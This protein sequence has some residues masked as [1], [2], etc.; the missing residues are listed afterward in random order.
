MVDPP[1]YR[2]QFENFRATLVFTRLRDTELEI[3]LMTNTE[4]LTRREAILAAGVTAG[5]MIAP[6]RSSASLASDPG[7]DAEPEE[8]FK[9]RGYYTIMT[10]YPT[11][12]LDVWKHIVDCMH[13]DGCNLLVY[14]LTGG[15][16]SKKYPETWQHN[17]DHVNIREDFTKELIDYAHAKQIRV[18]L[19]FTPFGYDGVNLHTKLHPELIAVGKDGKSTPEFGIFCWGHSLCPAQPKSQEFMLEYI[20]EMYFDFYPNADGLFI[21]SS[22]YSTCHCSEC[23]KNQGSGHFDNEFKFVK[24]IS[25]DVW[26]FKSDATIIVYPHYFSGDSVPVDGDKAVATKQSFDDRWTLFF[27]PHSTKINQTLIDRVPNS[28]YW[29]ESLIF[30]TPEK[31]KNSAQT[32]K[33]RRFNGYV[34]S[35][36]AYSYVPLRTEHDGEG[37]LVN[38][39]QIPF[40][41]GWIP[42]DQSP[43]GTLPI[44]VSRIAFREFSKDP[45]L[46][47]DAFRKVLGIEIFGERNNQALV[48]DL[49]SLQSYQTRERGWCLPSPIL[50]PRRVAWFASHG[51]LDLNRK[52]EFAN[53][54]RNLKRMADVYCNQTGTIGEL[55]RNARWIVDQWTEEFAGLLE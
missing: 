2:H 18:V 1:Q 44:R 34:P 17:Q 55:G 52:K 40:G 37:W 35:L 3:G 48:D 43:Y 19:G 5:I 11:A 31:V 41:I 26:R 10:R 28:I 46:S 12:G 23:S 29:D 7:S 15:F 20:R 54:V 49:M 33:A 53:A 36:E 16:R 21:E 38:R 45:E 39:R 13:E 27:T 6:W 8:A 50:E 47:M 9:H 30:A 14:W 42:P 22:D 25:E 32:A 24:T 4:I 51:T